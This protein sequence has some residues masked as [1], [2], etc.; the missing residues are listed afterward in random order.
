MPMKPPRRCT[1]CR[2]L[3][4]GPAGRCPEC[5]ERARRDSDQRRGGA[6]QRGYDTEHEQ[7]FR[8][9]VLARDPV[10]ML[11]GQLPSTVADHW[12]MS[13]RELE[14]RGL[15]PNDPAY[16][17]GLCDDCDK[18]QTARRQP[19]GWADPTRPRD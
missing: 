1:K 14:R 7:R 4:D 10:C 11:C 16:G 3:H 18:Q 8:T 6:R 17:R 12:P 19:G 15:D 2:R 9:V 5:A 13:R